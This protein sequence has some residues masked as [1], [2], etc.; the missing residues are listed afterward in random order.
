MALNAPTIRRFRSHTQPYS[1]LIRPVSSVLA[2]LF[3][4]IS[5]R[6]L[7]YLVYVAES[8]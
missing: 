6:H 1:F 3:C 8:V 2:V 4:L 5:I 7:M